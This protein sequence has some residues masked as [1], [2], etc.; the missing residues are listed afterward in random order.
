MNSFTSIE[1]NLSQFQ[2]TL[3]FG[4]Y[5]ALFGSTNEEREIYK[6]CTWLP[7]RDKKGRSNL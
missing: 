4:R 3:A 5:L 1:M 6:K 2:N 7:S